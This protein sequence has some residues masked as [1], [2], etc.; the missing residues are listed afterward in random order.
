MAPPT[1]AASRS[2]T[3]SVVS[4]D[5][6]AKP[7]ARLAPAA[8]LSERIDA[9]SAGSGSGAATADSVTA[10]PVATAAGRAD[11]EPERVTIAS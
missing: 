7:A 10:T 1:I 4:G 11:T 2:C 3:V 6:L 5:H 8:R 9:S